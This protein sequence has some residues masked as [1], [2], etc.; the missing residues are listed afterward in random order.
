ML[1][2]L[3][4]LE[5]RNGEYEYQVPV[6]LIAATMEIATKALERTAQSWYG[7]YS[8][9]Y[10]GGYYFYSG[11]ICVCAGGCKEISKFT[12]DEI[13]GYVVEATISEETMPCLN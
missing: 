13:A 2:F 1:Y 5:E 12:Y 6:R 8:H 3:G 10:N 7:D 11:E 9:K 4:I